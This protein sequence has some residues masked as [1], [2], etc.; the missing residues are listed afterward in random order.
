MYRRSRDAAVRLDLRGPEPPRRSFPHRDDLAPYTAS[1]G[2]S[3]EPHTETNGWHS[4]RGSGIR[5]AWHGALEHARTRGRVSMC[6]VGT[7][8]G[9]TG[10]CRFRAESWVQRV[11]RFTSIFSTNTFFTFGCVLPAVARH[12]GS[13]AEHGLGGVGLIVDRIN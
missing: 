13:Q 3:A 9:R 2:W 11:S 7:V 4:I 8:V 6:Y 12:E 5:G 1:Q 10:N